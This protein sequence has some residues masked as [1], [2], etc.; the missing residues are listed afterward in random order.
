LGRPSKQLISRERAARAALAVID[1]HG[2]EAFSVE[3]VARR[4][5]VRAPSLYYHFSDKS[6]LLSE[7]ARLILTDIEL[8]T[9]D[10]GDWVDAAIAVSVAVRRSILQHP[11]AAFLLLQFFPR[12]LLLRAYDLRYANCPVSEDQV[13]SVLEGAEK[14]TFG[15]ALFEA[16][17]RARGVDPMPPFD[18]DRLPTL[19]KAI[20]ANRLSDEELFVETLLRFFAGFGIGK[21]AAAPA[22]AG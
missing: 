9:Q 10:D 5:G 13:M 15:S 16:S 12:H 3:M 1:I 20:R 4:M 7:A 14:L 11:K 6:E 18:P 19:A 21:L 8:P 2:I 17:S 22:R